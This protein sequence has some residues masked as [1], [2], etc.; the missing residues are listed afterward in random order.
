V[1]GAARHQRGAKSALAAA[2]GGMRG[3]SSNNIHPVHELVCRAPQSR[4][5]N[6]AFCNTYGQWRLAAGGDG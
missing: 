6:E 4:I 1:G 2:D 3:W 5:F